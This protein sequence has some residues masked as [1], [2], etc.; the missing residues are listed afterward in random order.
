[1]AFTGQFSP[2]V[3]HAGAGW[4]APVSFV[5]SFSDDVYAV[6]AAAQAV[7]S[8]TS[9]EFRIRGSGTLIQ[10]VE[11]GIE[12]YDTLNVAPDVFRMR[13]SWDAGVNWGAWH[14]ITRVTPADT[15]VTEWFDVTA[16][17]PAGWTWALLAGALPWSN[18]IIEVEA[19]TTSAAAGSI[20]VDLI[21]VRVS[22]TPT[23]GASASAGD[24]LI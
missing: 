10:T 14:N 7:S 12:A 22:A 5:C 23:A 1:M 11:I 13:E 3:V 18:L 6:F 2:Y 15:N 21:D 8:L 9:K 19:D 16:E 20:F 24:V 17:P 4:V